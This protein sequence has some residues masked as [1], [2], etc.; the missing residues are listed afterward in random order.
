M[1]SNL[2]HQAF[3]VVS[4]VHCK[5]LSS[6]QKEQNKQEI[7]FKKDKATL[8]VIL[9]YHSNKFYPSRQIENLQTPNNTYNSRLLT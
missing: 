3:Q 9:I 4:D 7:V 1:T 6:N 2:R 8:H 5:E